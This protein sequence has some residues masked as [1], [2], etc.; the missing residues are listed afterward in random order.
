MW[1]GKR[2]K[3]LEDIAYGSNIQ[4]PEILENNYINLKRLEFVAV[5][6]ENPEPIL[7]GEKR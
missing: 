5:I 7:N 3:D 4:I 1:R 6:T 2:E